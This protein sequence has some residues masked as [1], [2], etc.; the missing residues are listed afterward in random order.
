MYSHLDS[1]LIFSPMACW[2]AHR[3]LWRERQKMFRLQ[4]DLRLKSGALFIPPFAYFVNKSNS[5]ERLNF[6]RFTCAR[7]N[8][9]SE[10]SWMGLKGNQKQESCNGLVYITH[11]RAAEKEICDSNFISQS[12]KR[13]WGRQMTFWW[14]STAEKMILAKASKTCI[15]HFRVNNDSF[16]SREVVFCAVC[17]PS[18]ESLKRKRKSHN[19]KLYKEGLCNCM[20]QW[21]D[22]N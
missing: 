2:R 18:L 7:L 21:N 12:F 19:C 6:W 15:T 14:T 11:K 20:A 17:T 9:N 1:L 3:T 8:R 22:V 4:S 5:M 16:P 10:Y 13:L